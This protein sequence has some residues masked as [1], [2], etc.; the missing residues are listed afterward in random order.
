MYCIEVVIVE[1][2]IG[3]LKFILICHRNHVLFY[4]LLCYLAIWRPYYLLHISWQYDTLICLS[5]IFPRKEKRINLYLLLMMCKFWLPCYFLVS[6]WSELVWWLCIN[7]CLQVLDELNKSR[8]WAELH[9]ADNCCFHYRRVSFLFIHFILIVGITYFVWRVVNHTSKKTMF[10]VL[11]FLHNT[12]QNILHN[13]TRTLLI[14]Y[15]ALMVCKFWIFFLFQGILN[16]LDH[17]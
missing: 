4:Y 8:K 5:C 15:Q 12:F 9:V 17:A 16:D 1:S 10:C 3:V 7:W 6:N 14:S 13:L 11:D 2:R